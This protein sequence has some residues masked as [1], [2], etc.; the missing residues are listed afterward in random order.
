MTKLIISL[1]R[2]RADI[3]E[4]MKIHTKLFDFYCTFRIKFNSTPPH[5]RR[6][7]SPE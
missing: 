3:K 4:A 7:F 1:Y 6:F 5:E 2:K